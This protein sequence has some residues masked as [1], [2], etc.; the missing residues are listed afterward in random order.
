MLGKLTPE[1]A[2]DE[3][4]R[5]SG[6]ADNSLVQRC[7][8]NEPAVYVLLPNQRAQSCEF[9]KIRI[10]TNRR[11]DCSEKPRETRSA[12]SL[13]SE[14]GIR[15]RPRTET[16]GQEQFAQGLKFMNPP[17]QSGPIR[18]K[19]NAMTTLQKSAHKMTDSG[20]KQWFAAANPDHRGGILRE[21]MHLFPRNGRGRAG[22]QDFRGVH[23]TNQR[24]RRRRIE[25]LRDA[26]FCEFCR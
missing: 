5:F 9:S 3:P 25:N 21:S 12:K 7:S 23:T 26:H 18:L 15:R 19:K 10:F 16:N 6:L 13:D 11:M 24:A 8:R 22:M 17:T 1:T 20:M 2:A 4:T 14:P